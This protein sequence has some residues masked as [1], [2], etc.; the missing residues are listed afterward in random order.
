MYYFKPIK[1]FTKNLFNIK[2]PV[3]FFFIPLFITLLQRRERVRERREKERKE[4]E[5]EKFANIC[6]F[7]LL[8]NDQ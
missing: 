7:L 5:K 1:Y 6:F 3:V 4:R 8:L 2:Y